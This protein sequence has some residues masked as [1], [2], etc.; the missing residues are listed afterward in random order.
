MRLQL[1]GFGLALMLLAVSGVY[2]QNGG[3][4]DAG[5]KI[6]DGGVAHG[7]VMHQRHA[8]DHSQ[9]LYYN[10]QS[11]HPIP[12]AE[13]QALVVGYKNSLTAA[14]KSLAKLKAEHTKNPE[15]LKLIASIEKHH[16]KAHKACDSADE[17]CQKDRGDNV[18][19]SG[20]CSDM[21]HELESARAETAKLVKLL[22][23]ESL[24]APKK[25]PA[26]PK[27]EATK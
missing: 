3:N 9:V 16:A 2:A 5:R 1:C 6:R 15:A 8:Q 12:K 22:K 21:Y 18:M 11:E 7:V 20:L 26:P 19:I 25:A 14:D 24:E 10:S 27:E 17:H 23:V 4:L 13:A